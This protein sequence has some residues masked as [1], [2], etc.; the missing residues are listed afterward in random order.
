MQ[1]KWRKTSILTYLF[2]ATVATD[3]D[4]DGVFRS[5]KVGGSGGWLTFTHAYTLINLSEIRTL[6]CSY[7]TASLVTPFRGVTICNNTDRHDRLTD[8]TDPLLSSVASGQYE[9]K[10]ELL[11][12]CQ[13]LWKVSG[14]G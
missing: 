11:S 7:T 2:A 14:P 3:E 5:S 12:P 8:M 13:M 4:F 10:I 1:E 9:C 6:I